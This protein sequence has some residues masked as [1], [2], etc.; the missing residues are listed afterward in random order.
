MASLSVGDIIL[1]TQIVYRLLT[2]ATIGRKS[3]LRDLREL[4]SVLLGLSCSLDHLQNVTA[5]ILSR[6]ANLSPESD[7]INLQQSF[8]VMIHSCRKAL[9][10]LEQATAKYRDTIKEPSSTQTLGSTGPSRLVKIKSQWRSFMWDFR[11]ESLTRYRQKLETHTAAINLMLNTFMWSSMDR[12]EN[13]TRRQ[14]Q[15]MEELLYQASYLNRTVTTPMHEVY[16]PGV[17]SHSSQSHIS[18]PR[19]LPESIPG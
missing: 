4:E 10:D 14:N 1:C 2:A 5:V 3:A 17:S 19:T 18:Y 9:E 11:G 7:A 16:L 12:I 6:E 13:D 8:G 15:R